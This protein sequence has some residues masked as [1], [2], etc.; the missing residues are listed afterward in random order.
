MWLRHQDSSKQLQPA[1]PP[2]SLTV[3]SENRPRQQASLPR[4]LQQE[5]HVNHRFTKCWTAG[6]S[7]TPPS[8]LTTTVN[9]ALS[10]KSK[11]SFK[12]KKE[13]NCLQN[14]R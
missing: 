10:A 2:D 8:I 5:K 6:L 13:N 3:H 12:L 11:L 1:T 4:L 7:A 9:H 14:L